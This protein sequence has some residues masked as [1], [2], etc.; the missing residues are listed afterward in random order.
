MINILGS[1]RA[2]H[3]L[4]QGNDGCLGIFAVVEDDCGLT[5]IFA[6]SKIT[7]KILGIKQ[8]ESFHWRE[9]RGKTSVLGRC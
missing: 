1:L 7:A 3:F 6:K 4:L 2:A 5:T 8:S 9:D